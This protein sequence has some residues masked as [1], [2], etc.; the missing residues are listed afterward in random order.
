VALAVPW[1][2][3]LGRPKT[4][5][6]VHA[7]VV[8]PRFRRINSD[9]VLRAYYAAGLGHPDKPDQQIMFGGRMSR[10]AKETGSMV[11]VDLP[12]GGTFGDAVKAKEKIASGL[13]VV[14]SR[15]SSPRTAPR[16]AGTSCSSPTATL[17]RSRWAHRHAGR[18]AAQHLAARSK[19]GRD[20]R[21][22]LVT[23][24]PAVELDPDRRDAAPRQDVLRAAA[25]A[26]RGTRPVGEDP[27]PPTA[28]RAPTTT[29][30]A[31]SRTGW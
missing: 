28:R 19:I 17:W 15:C 5:P 20:E 3:H 29:S 27:A 22:R 31:W 2:A 1:L 11:L 6:I 9:V 23:L 14:S 26:V 25:P 21:D 18:Q 16:N 30:S 8:D 24:A 10:D 4:A 13:D 7:A 12:F